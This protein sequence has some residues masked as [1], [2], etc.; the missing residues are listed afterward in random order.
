MHAATHD[1]YRCVQTCTPR[2]LPR[3]RSS[4]SF[5]SVVSSASRVRLSQNY[6][7]PAAVCNYACR[8]MPPHTGVLTAS[9]P[10]SSSLSLSV[11]TGGSEAY[12]P[13]VAASQSPSVLLQAYKCIKMHTPAY[14]C[15]TPLLFPVV[16]S[17]CWRVALGLGGSEACP[18][19]AGATS[20]SP[21]VLLQA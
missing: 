14:T 12:A 11:G 13:V 20:Q 9:S 3:H 10:S 1:A 16:S 2:N 5:T 7:P 21:S 19:L 15:S 8:C 17:F 18:D 4:E 6:C